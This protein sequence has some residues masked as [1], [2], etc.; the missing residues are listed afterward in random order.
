[1]VELQNPMPGPV[2]ES[3]LLLVCLAL[4]GC[5]Q[6]IGADELA[7]TQSNDG[8]AAGGAGGD[9]ASPPGIFTDCEGTAAPE[10]VKIEDKFCIDSTEVTKGQYL[11]FLDDQPTIEEPPFCAWNTSVD[12]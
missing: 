6:L 10:P 7:F 5:S 4:G 3:S 11:A 1:M 2:T 9:F 12:G 8:G